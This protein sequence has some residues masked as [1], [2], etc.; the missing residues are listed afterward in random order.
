MKHKERLFGWT[1]LMIGATMFIAV[2]AMAG[3]RPPS[4]NIG[5]AMSQVAASRAIR[6]P[7][8]GA[9]ISRGAR[10]LGGLP[11]SS[12]IRGLSSSGTGLGNSPFGSFGN[13]ANAAN[14]LGSLGKV[15]N[16]QMGNRD[17]QGGYP[18][19]PWEI[20]DH[21][22]ED[23]MAKAYRDVGIANAMVGLVGV[24]VQ[25]SQMSQTSQTVYCRPEPQGQWV[26]ERVLIAPAHYETKQ[27]WIPELHDPRT[28]Q[29]LG[30]GFHETRTEY[31]PDVYEERTVFV[32]M[33]SAPY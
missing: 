9:A 11:S 13:G 5:K 7:L 6:S 18:G 31:V 29:K 21:H 15:L 12:G 1:I 8:S 26:R 19:L 28:G 2:P 22:R 17:Y 25:A 4:L 20:Y 32:T 33:T 30:G 3:P 27:V 16:Q 23:Q 10:S 24:M 14:V